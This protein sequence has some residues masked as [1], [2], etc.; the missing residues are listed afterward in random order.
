MILTAMMV[1]MVQNFSIGTAITFTS[2]TL[3]VMGK[4]NISYHDKSFLQICYNRFHV[5]GPTHHPAKC[6]IRSRLKVVHRYHFQ[7]PKANDTRGC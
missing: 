4:L 7:G 6:L 2:S 5:H 3:S 1:K